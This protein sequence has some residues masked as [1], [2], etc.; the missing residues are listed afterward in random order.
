MYTHYKIKQAFKRKET[1][2][3]TSKLKR[4]EAENVESGDSIWD[5]ENAMK[6][7]AALALILDAWTMTMKMMSTSSCQA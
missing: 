3:Y 2:E 6:R 1:A 5:K 4:S 7:D